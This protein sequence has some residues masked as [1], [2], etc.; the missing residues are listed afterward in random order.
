[1]ITGPEIVPIERSKCEPPTIPRDSG[2][3]EPM[4][5][6]IFSVRYSPNLGDGLLSECLEAELLIRVPHASIETLDLAGRTRYVEGTKVRA[7]A[8]ATLHRSPQAIRHLLAETV[9][10]RRLQ[11]KLRPRWREALRGVHAVIV[12]GGNLFSDS[13]L[14][15][16]LKIDAAM[17]EVRAANLPAAVFAIGASDNWTDR[18]QALFRR[19]FVGTSL[20][21]ASARDP[22]SADVWR[23]RL[24]PVGVREACVVHD[25]GLLT[26]F[27]FPRSA[28]EKRNGPLIGLGLTHP[29]ALKYHSDERSISAQTQE[30]WYLELARSCVARGWRVA[31]FTNGSPEDEAYLAQLRPKLAGAVSD[32]AISF[33]PRFGNS[34]ELAAFVST[35]D[36]LMAHR[37]HANIAAYSY[38][39]PQ[40]GF[41]WDVK[42]KSFL[43]QVGR[44]HCI[45]TVGADSVETVIDLAR[46]QLEEGVDT[47]RHAALLAQ[48]RDDVGK[49]SDALTSSVFA[50]S[51]RRVRSPAPSDA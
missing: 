3:V 42:L 23:R 8:L 25:P 5:I 29:A 15:F 2:P 33:L 9:L 14:N 31:V 10:G 37:L 50:A 22:R 46:R 7:S 28:S 18:G 47:N 32:G 26:A 21:F 1:M 45:G 6:A 24:A 49:L 19:A 39:V 13:D 12:G 4:R 20:C 27:H 34:R 16:P 51:S 41:S 48:A 38:G 43:A 17:S 36:L 40:I 44:A 30:A 35:L 11:N